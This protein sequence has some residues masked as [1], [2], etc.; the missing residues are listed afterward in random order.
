VSFD[1]ATDREGALLTCTTVSRP[2]TRFL[3]GALAVVTLASCGSGASST[4][5]ANT[6]S[7]KLTMLTK[8]RC[9]DLAGLADAYFKPLGTKTTQAAF[10]TDSDGSGRWCHLAGDEDGPSLDVGTSKAKYVDFDS[11][12]GFVRSDWVTS[13]GYG[14][15]REILS[16]GWSLGAQ[17]PRNSKAVTDFWLV[18]SDHAA[19]RC[20]AASA[21][22]DST[23]PDA[24]AVKVFCDQVKSTLYAG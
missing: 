2:L 1:R 21:R 23:L 12:D 11:Y 14:E 22:D 8:S 15:P 7:G 10:S 9:D 19:M 13:N 3:A 4:E 5:G 24:S 20:Y 6:G 17:L 18:L 16:T